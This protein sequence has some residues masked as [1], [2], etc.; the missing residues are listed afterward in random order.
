MNIWCLSAYPQGIQDVGDF[1]KTQ[2]QSVSHIMA[3]NGTHGFERQTNIHRQNQI[4]PC[5]LWRY[6]EVLRHETIGLCKKVNSIHIIF[7]LC[8]T[9]NSVTVT[10]THGRCCERAQDS[11]TLQWIRA[12][13]WYKYCL[14]SCTDRS[15]RVLRPQCIVMSLFDSQSRGSHWLPL[16]DWQTATVW[17]KNL[18]LCSTEETS[19]MPWG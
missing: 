2:T 3:V 10:Y 9:V 13:N 5:G 16:Y 12:K 11:W 14:L 17:V 6:I 8:P 15:F 19:L 18:R 7:F 1:S 4:K